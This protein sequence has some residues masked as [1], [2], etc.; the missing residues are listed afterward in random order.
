QRPD[1]LP[2]RRPQ[3]LRQ[4]PSL[5]GP[6]V[7]RIGQLLPGNPRA[8]L[9]RRSLG[10]LLGPETFRKLGPLLR[11]RPFFYGSGGA[12]GGGG[13]ANWPGGSAIVFEAQFSPS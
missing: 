2:P 11:E 6:G 8:L 9:P 4:G 5:P 13:A 10:P 7:R 1:D 12:G 3:H